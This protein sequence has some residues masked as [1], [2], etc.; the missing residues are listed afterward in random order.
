MC[1]S[2]TVTMNTQIAR[3][4]EVVASILKAQHANPNRGDAYR[5]AAITVR[6]LHEPLP[7]ILDRESLE[8]SLHCG[9]GILDL[10][11]QFVAAAVDGR[12]TTS[13]TD[14]RRGLAI[15]D[16]ALRRAEVLKPD[17]LEA[18]QTCAGA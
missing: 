17:V 1:T 7:A 8:V 5:R 12:L 4:L 11:S 2:D 18:C 15:D 9:R 16:Y 10:L 14:N 13:A 3:R 6:G